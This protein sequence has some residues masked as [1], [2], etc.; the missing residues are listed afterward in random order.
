MD[1]HSFFESDVMAFMISVKGKFTIVINI[2][3]RGSKVGQTLPSDKLPKW[4]RRV[5]K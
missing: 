3:E 1:C 2:E 4:G 5:S